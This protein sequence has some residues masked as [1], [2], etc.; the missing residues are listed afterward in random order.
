MN[1]DDKQLNREN[2]WLR[3]TFKIFN[4]A[5]FNGAIETPVIIQ[6]SDIKNSGESVVNNDGTKEINIHIGLL[7]FRKLSC[8]VLLHEMAHLYVGC[9]LQHGIRWSGQIERLYM[10]GAYEEL[11]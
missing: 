5:Y 2:R 11:L 1:V 7:D 8:T 4:D 9:E 6:Y 10:I 3:K